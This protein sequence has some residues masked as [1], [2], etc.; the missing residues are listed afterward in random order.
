MGTMT[1]LAEAA[2][3]PSWA[4]IITAVT[5]LVIAVG[6]AITA[7]SM[8]LT[9]RRASRRLDAY[10]QDTTSR[11]RV[12][13]GL[14]NSTLTASMQSDLDA[15]RREL[16]ITREVAQLRSDAGQPVPAGFTA[17]VDAL[18]RKIA[19][20]TLAMQ[21]RLDQAAAMDRQMLADSPA[22]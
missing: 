17:A 16:L 5:S 11:L 18:E 21:D 1:I 20:L 14:V 13:H 3:A 19:A 9:R 4:G 10:Q 7:V 6:G 2:T 12:I 22:G 15:S 8:A